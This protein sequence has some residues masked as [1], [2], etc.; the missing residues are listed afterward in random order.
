MRRHLWH[1]VDADPALFDVSP[2]CR[3]DGEPLPPKGLSAEALAAIVP[4]LTRAERGASA[5]LV[6]RDAVT[7]LRSMTLQRTA[8]HKCAVV[9]RVMSCLSQ[10]AQVR[11]K[12]PLGAEE[13]LPLLAWALA[14]SRQPAL[15]AQLGFVQAVLPERL[16]SQSDGY[17]IASLTGAVH[18]LKSVADT[19]ARKDEH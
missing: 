18:A 15:L 14:R 7:L 19:Y 10:A 4:T 12:E 16:L 1:C 8:R 5:E 11:T 2:R 6:Y 13:L 9:A 17:T 3:F